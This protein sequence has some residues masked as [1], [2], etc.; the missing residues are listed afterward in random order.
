MLVRRPGSE[1]GLTAFDWL[2]SRHSFSFAEYIDRSQMGF[3]TLRVI[4]DDRIAPSSGFG[5]HPHRDMEIITYMIDGVLEHKD[6]LGNGSMIRGGEVQRMTAGTGI[7]HSEMNPSSETAAH[8]LQIWIRPA[9]TGLTP[10]YEQKKFDPAARKGR[11]VPLAA[12][13]SRDGAVKVHQDIV[14]Y[15]AV[16]GA[17]ETVQHRFDDG[18]AGWLQVA[19][20]SASINGENL[21]EGDGIAITDEAAISVTGS[22]AGAD[23]LLFDLA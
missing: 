15:G 2:E 11:W 21:E 18:R 1:R 13:D 16:L 12:P 20:G 10:G 14:L 9:E 4:N 17:D 19:Q 23:L 22:G 3:R 8:L 6:S 5:T 7:Q